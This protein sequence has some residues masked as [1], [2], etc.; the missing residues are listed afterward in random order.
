LTVSELEPEKVWPWYV[1]L[2]GIRLLE[3]KRGT[4]SETLSTAAEVFKNVLAARTRLP[5]RRTDGEVRRES[6]LAAVRF[7]PAEEAD[8]AAGLAG[9]GRG[10]ARPLGRHRRDREEP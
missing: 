6:K 5:T 10:L 8:P 4:E 1:Q 9:I 7:R 2:P 3:S